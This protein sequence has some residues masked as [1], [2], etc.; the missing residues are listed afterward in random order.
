MTIQAETLNR[1]LDVHAGEMFLVHKPI[2][3]SSFDVVN[4]MRAIFHCERIGHAGTLD[5]N[6][7][8]LLI[9]CTGRKTKM[10]AGFQELDKEYDVTMRLGERTE[11][12]DSETPVIERH[13]TGH[14]TEHSLRCVCQRFVGVHSQLPPMWSAA[15][16]AGR[17]LYKYARKG[18]EVERRLRV[19]EVK[20]LVVRTMVLPDAQFTVTCS[21]GTYIRTLV[22]DIG[23]ALGTGAHVTALQR[24]RIGEFS[25]ANALTI[26]DLIRIR[27]VHRN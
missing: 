12:Y 17:R 25:L 14:L 9:V 27:N 22:N 16:V 23:N 2:G 6:A 3:W 15:K 10:L 11:S 8:G 5:Q 26:D 7:T 1:E 24:T 4:K 13:D 21:K 19:V 18:E 20:S